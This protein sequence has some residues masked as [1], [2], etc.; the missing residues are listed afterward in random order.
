VRERAYRAE[1][2]IGASAETVFTVLTR[3]SEYPTWNPFTSRVVSTLEV[4]APVR[5]RVHLG[6]LTLTQVEELRQIQPPDA[7]AGRLVWGIY[8]WPRWLL[9]AERVQTVEPLGPARCRYR[10]VDTIGGLLQPLVHRLF[11]RALD[12]GFA[13]VAAALRERAESESG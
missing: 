13:A 7:E 12:D 5:M 2:E 6:R 4:G 3:L 10:T 11:G 1:A 8:A 9:R